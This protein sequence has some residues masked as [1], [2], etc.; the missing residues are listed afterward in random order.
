MSRARLS[1][2]ALVIAAVLAPSCASRETEPPIGTPEPDKF[3]IDRGTESLQNEKWFTAREYFRRLVDGYP[4]S[5]YRAD[6]KLGIGDTYIGE[7][8]TEAFIFAQNEFREFLTFYPTHDRADYAQYRLGL[9]HFEQMLGPDRDQTQTKAAIDEFEAFVKRF[10]Q[11]TYLPEVQQKLREAKDR[12]SESDY[13]VGRFYYTIRNYAGAIGRFQEILKRDPE[14]TRRDAVYF[15]LAESLL[16]SDLAAAALPYYERLVTEF[17]QS[18]YLEEAKR[19]I[20]ELK[21]THVQDP[22]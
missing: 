5:V 19:R 16:K 9:A 10:P 2:V 7:G 17:V 1:L 12:L 8:T 22:H 21:K 14:F 20:A 3:L 11:S 15:H 4:Q 6:A 18:E 13:R